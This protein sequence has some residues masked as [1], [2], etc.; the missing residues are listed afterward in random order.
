MSSVQVFTDVILTSELLN[1]SSIS[2]VHK[3]TQQGC[4]VVAKKFNL[5]A[6]SQK[7][8]HVARLLSSTIGEVIELCHPNLVQVL[9]IY[10]A[11]FGQPIIITEHMMAGSLRERLM[12]PDAAP[13]AFRETVDINLGVLR[14]LRYLHE[15][16]HPVIHARLSDYNVLLGADGC[17]KLS[18]YGMSRF[19]ST[20]YSDHKHDGD[21]V[22]FLPPE[23]LSKGHAPSVK[24]DVFAVGVLLLECLVSSPPARGD[25][26]NQQTAARRRT[27]DLHRA[28]TSKMASTGLPQIISQC[29]EIQPYRRPA[30]SQLEA[31]VQALCAT[32]EYMWSDPQAI[33]PAGGSDA[34]NR[35][36]TPRPN[37]PL[38][39]MPTENS[40]DS[41]WNDFET[42]SAGNDTLQDAA[43]F[44]QESSVATGALNASGILSSADSS[45]DH[46]KSPSSLPLRVQQESIALPAQ[47]PGSQQEEEFAFVENDFYSSGQAVKEEC[48]NIPPQPVRQSYSMVNPKKHPADATPEV[49]APAYDHLLPE[50]A[51]DHLLPEPACDQLLSRVAAVA[52]DQADESSEPPGQN[53]EF[54]FV[55]N[56]LYTSGS[57]DEV[58][59]EVGNHSGQPV[60]NEMQH[61]MAGRTER[62][63]APSA[64]R[65]DMTAAAGSNPVST[66]YGQPG[67]FQLDI[68]HPPGLDEENH[69][70]NSAATHPSVRPKAKPRRSKNRLADSPI[71]QRLSEANH[72]SSRG[73]S[74]EYV[75][76]PIRLAPSPPATTRTLGSPR[77][78]RQPSAAISN[79]TSSNSRRHSNE[80]T[81][82]P[83]RLP[84]TSPATTPMMGS[85]IIAPQPS[86]ASSGNDYSD[87]PSARMGVQSSTASPL[88]RSP[89]ADQPTRVDGSND[90]FYVG[91]PAT[92]PISTPT[93]TSRSSSPQP[94][95]FLQAAG[96]DKNLTDELVKQAI[97]LS[98]GVTV[99]AVSGPSHP[100]PA[101]PNNGNARSPD[102]RRAMR[103]AASHL[104][105]RQGMTNLPH[106]TGD[107]FWSEVSPSYQQRRSPPI[108][109]RGSQVA[110]NR[111]AAMTNSGL[112]SYADV[113]GADEEQLSMTSR[114]LNNSQDRPNSWTPVQ[115][116]PPV[117]VR[118]SGTLSAST[119]TASIDRSHTLRHRGPAV[120]SDALTSRL[121]RSNTMQPSRRPPGSYR[122]AQ[123]T[124]VG[125]SIY[126]ILVLLSTSKYMY[127]MYAV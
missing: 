126:I 30:C 104:D 71:L 74:N 33:Q 98:G 20:Y 99:P 53:D 43:G 10:Q 39:V 1:R 78:A 64:L 29:F 91:Q 42:L 70:T 17:A 94:A 11:Q 32:T 34:A 31:D 116:L 127:K 44:H 81:D 124:Q 119:R 18:D 79:T 12:A 76:E 110:I 83:I 2:S 3:A 41:K 102:M 75:D 63:T 92:P 84:P 27:A 123:H 40:T 66:F 59:E 52:T 97:Q 109:P 38:A 108:I 107:G 117:P 112:P 15:L 4:P 36:S 48:A 50:P 45:N 49:H 90:Y 121:V 120:G 7:S 16:P 80:Y 51:Y 69:P 85:P 37:A 100:P 47:I 61:A 89:E 115:D 72:S 28:Q 5:A 13:L 86:A 14:G 113:I 68:Q 88:S 57:E 67:A 95:H 82:E 54:I 106:S 6:A 101:K 122:S 93:A 118:R 125:C 24:A 46:Y 65:V 8:D 77:I 26:L 58:G 114:A 21:L 25:R 73:S 96:S 22:A 87:S 19:I 105:D 62:M 23:V 9:G 35:Y 111:K 55:E 103:S 56:H 60:E